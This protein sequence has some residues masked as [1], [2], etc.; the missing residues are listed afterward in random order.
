M[1]TRSVS[2]AVLAV[3]IGCGGAQVRQDLAPAIVPELSPRDDLWRIHFVDVGQG[4]AA[5]LEFP[6]A[7]MLVDTG[8]ETDERFDG[9]AALQAYLDAFFRRRA[10]LQGTLALLALTHPHIDH[11][12]GG[13][14]VIERYR[15]MNVIDNGQSTGSGGEQQADVQQWAKDHAPAVGYRAVARADIGPGG[16]SDGVI[17]PIACPGV[18]PRIVALWGRVDTD[19]GWPGIRFGK[20]PFQNANNHSV[21]LRI[22]Y[23]EASALFTGDLEE[24]AIRDLVA[25]SAALLDVDV[26]QVGHHGSINGT[27]PE[28][29]AAMTPE[30][31]VFPMG[32]PDWHLTWSAWKYG[33]PRQEIVAMLERGITRK[34]KPLDVLVGVRGEQFAPHRIEQAL[35]STAWDGTVVIEAEAD[36]R[37]R[38]LTSPKRWPM[39]RLHRANH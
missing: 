2:V 1:A 29:V 31:A 34:R 21:V 18:D 16:L 25:T 4:L 19:P 11:T 9:T 33:H 7:A 5:L 10:D 36:G 37:M 28:L 6:C 14:M 22:D 20:T 12:R 38:V 27:L 39:G 8:G 32:N 30:I 13:T 35:Y 26:Y 23:G 3:L 17:D 24:P 15:V